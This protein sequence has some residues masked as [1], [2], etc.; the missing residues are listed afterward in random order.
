MF[1]IELSMTV[2]K[3]RALEHREGGSGRARAT[4]T[5]HG[6]ARRDG[7]GRSDAGAQWREGEGQHRQYLCLAASVSTAVQ[8]QQESPGGDVP[9]G[10]DSDNSG[11]L[12]AEEFKIPCCDRISRSSR[13]NLLRFVGESVRALHVLTGSG[14]RCIFCWTSRLGGE[15]DGILFEAE[16]EMTVRQGAIIDSCYREVSLLEVP[17]FLVDFVNSRRRVDL[18]YILTTARLPT[19]QVAGSHLGSQPFQTVLVF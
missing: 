7:T 8:R 12:L 14:S 11:H 3:A 16:E 5:R 6:A 1:T 13:K 2:S 17:N 18:A 4:G 15:C 9:S 10:V 19:L